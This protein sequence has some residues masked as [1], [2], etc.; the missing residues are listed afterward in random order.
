MVFVEKVVDLM[1]N[2]NEKVERTG[3][4]ST[5]WDSIVK[6]YHKE[7]LIP[8]WI[9]DMDF[10]APKSVQDALANFVSQGIFGYSFAPESLYDAIIQWQFH[11][12]NYSLKKEEIL[13]NTG[14]VPSITT[15]VHAYSNL[16][17]SVLIT[18]PVYPPFASA[19]V[20]AKR[21]L[22]RSPLLEKDGQF[23]FDFADMEERIKEHQVKLFIL[24]NPHNPGG[25]VWTE[26]ELYQ[27]GKLCQ[28]Y[29]VMVISDE[30]HQDLILPGHQFHSFQTV[31]PD[32]STFS[33]VFTAP[34][35][36]FN[37]AGIKNSMIFIKNKELREKMIAMQ[38]EWRFNEISTFGYVATEAAY[39]SCESWLDEL[40]VFFAKQIDLV[41]THFATFLPKVNVMKPQ[42]TY[43]MWLDFSAYG[44]TDKELQDLLV[45][46]AGVVLN[47][48][49]LFGPHGSQHL[50]LNIAC[51]EE[52][53]KEGLARLTSVFKDLPTK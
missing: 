44:L 6:T 7:N 40:L 16:G 53:L 42:G 11:R 49:S 12:H 46:Q 30:I 52:L 43:L 33:I 27:V 24:C 14:V 15:A 22:V 1:I 31:D 45:E 41:C 35:K 36:T 48:G 32:F 38:N 29:G 9:A 47:N 26:E 19:V 2:F 20:E 10:K 21:N 50:R 28:K 3:T 34:T 8:L 18:D 23:V 5:K 51:Q 25:R 39:Q 37:L 13:F 17:D 4:N